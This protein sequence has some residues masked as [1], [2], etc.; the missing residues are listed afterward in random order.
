MVWLRCEVMR[1]NLQSLQ[2]IYTLWPP[3]SE[4]VRR[5]KR[6]CGS[7]RTHEQSIVKPEQ[8]DMLIGIG[9]NNTCLMQPTEY[10][11]A[12]RDAGVRPSSVGIAKY[13]RPALW[14]LA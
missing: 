12:A 13:G 7:D 3:E 9:T 8:R 14:R 5:A 4:V 1:F 11:D 6:M 10:L 2:D